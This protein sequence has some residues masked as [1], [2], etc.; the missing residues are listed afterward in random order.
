MPTIC[1]FYGI[2]IRMYFRDHPPPHFHAIYG[3]AEAVI[4]IHSM[5]VREGR[6]P[7]RATALVLEWTRL[8]QAELVHA[9]DEASRHNPPGQIE[10]LD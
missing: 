7:R 8:H 5:S 3:G 10:P 2:T 1:Q 9:W 4:D 6:L